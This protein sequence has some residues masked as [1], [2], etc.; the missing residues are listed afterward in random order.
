V[1]TG[2]VGA[3]PR[4]DSDSDPFH[5]SSAFFAN[6]TGRGGGAAAS[7]EY[8]YSDPLDEGS[9]TA[10]IFSLI[11]LDDSDSREC[12]SAAGSKAATRWDG[13]TEANRTGGPLDSSSLHTSDFLG[14]IFCLESSMLSWPTMDVPPAD[15]S[16]C[17]M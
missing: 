1:T 10:A 17:E 13:P 9:G 12:P 8:S 16:R 3:A 4:D 15:V 6:T 5:K 11:K 7:L 14:V 2:G